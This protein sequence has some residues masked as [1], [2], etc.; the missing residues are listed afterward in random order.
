MITVADVHLNLLCYKLR[1]VVVFLVTAFNSPSNSL[2]SLFKRCKKH[3]ASL[4]PLDRLGSSCT[5]PLLNR[6]CSKECVS[7][8][9]ISVESLYRCSTLTDAPFLSLTHH[10]HFASLSHCLF[11]FL[12]TCY[13]SEA[14]DDSEMRTQ[15][16][17]AR[18]APPLSASLPQR[19]HWPAQTPAIS[20][21]VSFL[22]LGMPSASAAADTLT[23]TPHTR[24]TI[25]SAWINFHTL[26]LLSHLSSSC[27]CVCSRVK[28]LIDTVYV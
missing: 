12:F 27:A 28:F 17:L 20:L 10:L 5:Q 18:F 16:H 7:K 8:G 21:F 3:L 14:D 4:P 22:C 19:M 26:L 2:H 1:S 11:S 24:L 25:H 6:C 9:S 15:V 13:Q 23:I